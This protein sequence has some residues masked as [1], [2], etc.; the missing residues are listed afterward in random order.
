MSAYVYLR[1]EINNQLNY[2]LVC[3]PSHLT[4]L[5]SVSAIHFVYE[6]TILPENLR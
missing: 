6:V 5:R 2:Q 3:L 1:T 4:T